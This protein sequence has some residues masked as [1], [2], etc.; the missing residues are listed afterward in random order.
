MPY[1]DP[2]FWDRMKFRSVLAI[3]I[4]VSGSSAGAWAQQPDHRGEVI[5]E[6]PE[7]RGVKASAPIPSW[8]HILNEGGSDGAG[9]CVIASNVIDGTYQDVPGLNEGKE[10]PVW[11]LAKKRP[12]GYYPSKLEALFREAGLQTAW[13]S[14]EGSADE[15]LPVIEY[16][17]GQGIPVGVTMNTGRFYQYQTIAHMVSCLHL[18]ANW[19]CIVDNN[20]PG[21]YHWMPRDEFARRLTGGRVGWIVALLKLATSETAFMLVYAAAGAL[22]AAAF[23]L[24][25]STLGALIFLPR[26]Q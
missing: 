2:Y 11:L 5:T 23:V 10:S 19:A 8:M 9:L 26:R 7:W 1:F 4:L 20:N 21:Y 16:Y 24:V 13:F 12:G 3:L 22:I 25:F 15:L 6:V 18:D 14:A 17:T